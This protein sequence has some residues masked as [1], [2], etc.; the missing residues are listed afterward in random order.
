[1]I[2]D[3]R[4]CRILGYYGDL[5]EIGNQGIRQNEYSVATRVTRLRIHCCQLLNPHLLT[6]EQDPSQRRSTVLQHKVKKIISFPLIV[7]KWQQ[8]G[9]NPGFHYPD[10]NTRPGGRQGQ[11]QRG[12]LRSN[13]RTSREFRYII[14]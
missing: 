6:K 7:Q 9:E 13:G 8:E 11:T 10:T 3:A 14:C 5:G 12:V 4:F 1:V 2:I